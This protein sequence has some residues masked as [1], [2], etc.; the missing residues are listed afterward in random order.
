MRATSTNSVKLHTITKLVEYSL[1]DVVGKAM[2]SLTVLEILLSEGGSVLF[3]TQRHTWSKRVKVSMKNQKE[4]GNLLAFLEKWFTYGIRRFWMV[5]KFFWFG[6]YFLLEKQKKLGIC[7]NCLKSD[8]LTSLGGLEWFLIFFILFNS[9]SL[10]KIG[11][12]DFWDANNYA[13]FKHQ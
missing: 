9:F 4:I 2:F 12:L 7:W 6:L 3:P 5:F 13:R 10:G 11:K 8:W 1:K